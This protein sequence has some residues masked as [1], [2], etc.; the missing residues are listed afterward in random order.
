MTRRHPPV[1]RFLRSQW[2][3]DG[4]LPHEPSLVQ[5][6]LWCCSRL[7]ALPVRPPAPVTFQA[8]YRKADR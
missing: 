1:A 4:Y 8:Y 5:I 7:W 6:R 2:A 3:P